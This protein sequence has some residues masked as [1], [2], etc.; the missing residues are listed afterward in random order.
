MPHVSK[1]IE[2]TVLVK[3]H[4]REGDRVDFGEALVDLE[5]QEL[6]Q[7]RRT[8]NAAALAGMQE[9]TTH[10]RSNP[11]FRQHRDISVPVRLTASYTAYLRKIEVGEG[12]RVVVGQVLALVTTTPIEPLEDAVEGSGRFRVVANLVEGWEQA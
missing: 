3:W 5:V 7:L 4:K 2:D 11:E 9:P 6:R 1:Q 12:G 8:R 10:E